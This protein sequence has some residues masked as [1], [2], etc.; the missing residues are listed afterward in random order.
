MLIWL[1][2]IKKLAFLA[3]CGIMITGCV[4]SP[5]PP[6]DPNRFI[7]VPLAKAISDEFRN[8]PYE[9][10]YYKIN[11]VFNRIVKTSSPLADHYYDR[12]E[13]LWVYVSSPEMTISCNVL[14]PKKNADLLYKLHTGD[15]ITI[16]GQPHIWQL[17][18]TLMQEE[19]YVVGERQIGIVAADIKRGTLD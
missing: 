4:A 11:A 2:A 18:I 19:G 13:W 12:S 3:M 14:V 7:S 17:D 9:N 5:P 6:T 10:K 16:Y 8:N 15:P 1:S